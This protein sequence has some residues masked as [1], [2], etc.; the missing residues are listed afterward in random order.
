M[1]HE[2]NL[3]AQ[4]ERWAEKVL[5]DN[6]IL[7]DK[8]ACATDISSS[9][10]I[11]RGLIETIKFLHLCSHSAVQ[12]VPSRIVDDIWHEFILFTRAYYQFCDEYLGGFIH[13]QPSSD[14]QSNQSGYQQTLAMYQKEFGQPDDIYWPNMD[15]LSSQC[16][17]CEN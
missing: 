9:E 12:L 16:G 14:V 15:N 13:H 10:Q 3:T 4:I 8:L 1:A 7:H 11:K 17:L 2:Q 5:T 6:P